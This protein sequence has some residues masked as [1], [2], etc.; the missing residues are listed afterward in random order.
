ML[1]RFVRFILRSL[2]QLLRAKTRR[3]I[4]AKEKRRVCSETDA[5]GAERKCCDSIADTK[6]ENASDP[7]ETI[8][9]QSFQKDG[10]NTNRQE[11]NLAGWSYD[12]SMFHVAGVSS[13]MVEFFASRAEV[14]ARPNG[15]L[16]AKWAVD[17]VDFHD[18]ITDIGKGSELTEQ[19]RALCRVIRESLAAS[20]RLADIHM[21]DS[22]T[23]NPN[24]QRAVAVTRNA[25]TTEP[26]IRE[27][28]ATGLSVRGSLL[29]K[30]EVSLV[31]PLA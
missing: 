27:K 8:T 22:D 1:V 12:E 6:P 28:G 17:A 18:E 26:L 24:I 14:L 4:T 7:S 13:D 25:S 30:Q 21:L 9:S 29:R 23:W 19:E 10:T 16:D 2:Q 31:M 20:F 5:Q 11:D 15:P 3:D